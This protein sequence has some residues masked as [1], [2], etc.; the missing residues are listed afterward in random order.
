MK[1][2]DL[3]RLFS[4]FLFEFYNQVFTFQFERHNL[5][6]LRWRQRIFGFRIATFSY[7]PFILPYFASTEHAEE[8]LAMDRDGYLVAI[9][10]L[11]HEAGR[12]LSVDL[13]V[14]MCDRFDCVKKLEKKAE[15]IGSFR[16]FVYRSPEASIY[17]NRIFI[18]IHVHG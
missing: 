13:R 4:S 18:C 8:K 1:S 17:M 10:V 15:I 5:F 9:F 3:G 7:F 2:D 11:F 14:L 16:F 12:S 6:N